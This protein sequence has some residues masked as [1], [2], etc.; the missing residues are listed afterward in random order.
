MVSLNYTVEHNKAIEFICA[1]FKYVANQSQE[2]ILIN[3]EIKNDVA[4]EVLDFSP[5]KEVK[6]WLQYVDD[7]ISPFFR[8]DINL[9]ISKLGRLLDACIRVVMQNNIEDADELIERIKSTDH[10]ELLNIIYNEYELGIPFN[11][12][13]NILKKALIEQFDEETALFFL[14][15]KHHS[16]EYKDN[17]IRILETFNNLY[18]KP[19]EDEVYDFMQKKL[20]IHNKLFEKNKIEFLN[21]IG[22][23]DYSSLINEKKNLKII[24]SFYLDLALFHF[25]IDDTFVLLYGHSME[26]RFDK[27]INLENSKNL[28]KVLS[29][30]KRLEIIRVTSQRPWYNKELANYFR[31]ST[32]TLSYHLNL[33]LDLGILNFE[34]SINNRYCYTTNKVKLKHL[35]DSAVDNMLE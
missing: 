34:P 7:D 1:L 29:D 26:Q 16:K 19:F 3:Q 10:S 35:L 22:L 11:S 23:G 18:Y 27:K 15:T 2:N 17:A 28:F 4:K 13:E 9:I 21:T 6:Q 25:N 30:E 31:L 14:Q 5:S 32:A 33:L 20:Q 8:N 24:T 12:K